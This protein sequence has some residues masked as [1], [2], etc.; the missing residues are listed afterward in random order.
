MTCNNNTLNS[1]QEIVNAFA[2]QFASVFSHDENHICDQFCDSV[3]SVCKFCDNRCCP[4]LRIKPGC[5]YFPVL[6]MFKIDDCDIL[7]A[8][9][10]IKCNG[11]SGPDG[12]PAYIV[13]DCINCFLFPICHIFNLILKTTSYPIV[14]KNSK[15]CPIFKSGHKSDIKNYR[16]VALLSNF[17]KLFECILSEVLYSHVVNFIN[18]EQHGFVKGKS[19]ATNLFEFTQF[20]SQALDERKQ[21]DVVYTDLTK[22]FDKVHHC[23]LLNKLQNFGLSCSLVQLLKSVTMCRRQYVEY[24]S[25]QSEEFSCN[26]G[27]VQGSNLGPLLFIIFFND[28]CEYINCKFYVYAD[29]LKIVNIINSYSDCLHLQHSIDLFAEYCS[30]NF[31]RINTAKCKVMSI[32]RKHVN[33]GFFY[34]ILGNVLQ[35]CEQFLDLG[36]IVDNTLSFVPHINSIIQK[37]LKLLGFI[38]RNTSDMRNNFTIKLLFYT[39]V[40]SRLEYCC[41]VWYPWQ[42]T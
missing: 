36:V 19:T 42:I 23:I 5:E 4:S 10:K 41:C 27:V 26:S 34:N 31:L 17:A 16:P 18:K 1:P 11:V 24:S 7:R 6:H 28:V 2:R 40:R 15:I 39:L 8:V 35:R 20:A 37:G 30:R 13:V 25:Y 14:W 21:V 32:S 33:V 29:D 38:I 9:K 12:V 22:A 3:N